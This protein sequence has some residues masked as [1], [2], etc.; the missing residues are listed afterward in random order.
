MGGVVS[1][2]D[3]RSIEAH[4]QRRWAEAEVDRA[5]R[6]PGRRKFYNY[7][8]GP[9]PNGPLHMGHVRTYLLGDCIARYRRLL[10]DDVLYATEWDAFGL[11]IELEA[12]K[13]GQDPQAFTEHWIATM[14]EQLQ[15]LGISYD[16]SRVR[17][18]IDPRYVRWT[19]QLFLHWWR[20]GIIEQREASAPFCASC[21]TT[22][23]RMQVDQGRCW[24]CA[25]VVEQR[26]VPQWFV[27]RYSRP[28]AGKDHEI[29]N[30]L[31][32]KEMQLTHQWCHFE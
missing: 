12:E 31:K 32:K 3:A 9:F 15:T 23:A 30:L 20:H 14:R 25:S 8:S 6:R 26:R 1:D 24:R 11:P 16:W 10:G 13:Q 28:R 2:Y 17:S 7:D 19:Q 5:Q 4:W 27:R 18:T 21:G 29:N 22:L